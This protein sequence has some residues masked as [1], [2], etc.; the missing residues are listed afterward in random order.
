VGHPPLA[1]GHG[2]SEEET[3]PYSLDEKEWGAASG[4]V[5]PL[6]TRG[7]FACVV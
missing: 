4:I 6:F 5:L 3:R 2:P 1:Y 7:G